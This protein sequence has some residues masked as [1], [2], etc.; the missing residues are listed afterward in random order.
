MD[1]QLRAT[2][3]L[4]ESSLSMPT[5]TEKLDAQVAHFSPEGYARVNS[6]TRPRNVE[7]VQ[8]TK[9]RRPSSECQQMLDI[10]SGTGDFTR[11]V[12]L[13]CSRPCRKMVAVDSLPGMVD[14]AKANY[15]HPDISYEVLDASTPDLSEFLKRHGKFDRIYSF[16]C[17]HWIRDQRQ[18]FNNVAR[19]LKDG[20]ECLLLFCAPFVVHHVWQEMAEMRRWRAIVDDPMEL[21]P[22]IWNRDSRISLSDIETAVRQLVADAGMVTLACDVEP[23]VPCSFDRPEGV[24]D[25]LLPIVT[26]RADASEEQKDGLRTEVSSRLIAGCTHTASGSSFPIDIF[27]LHAQKQ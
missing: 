17:W 25:M 20:G 8:N 7:A 6:R 5:L 9:Y 26:T 12:L 19:M 15:A 14:Y 16:Y 11:D 24:L 22:E 13:P 2:S 1:C 4:F 18:A 23:A 21:F 27:V 3:M 10:G